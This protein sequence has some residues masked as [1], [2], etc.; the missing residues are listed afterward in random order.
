MGSVKQIVEVEVRPLQATDIGRIIDIDEKLAGGERTA[1]Q[2]EIIISDIESGENLSF[3]ASADGKVVGF[4]I[5][6]HVYL[7]EPITSTAAI[8]YIGVDPDYARHG[9]ASRLVNALINR[10]RV[11][12]IKAVRTIISDRDSK[13]EGFFKRTGFTPA[14]LKVFGKNI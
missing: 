11:E 10:S 14:K 3:V 5:A 12:G 8:Q 1:N 9:I 7:G 6:R 4:L 2:A 13:L